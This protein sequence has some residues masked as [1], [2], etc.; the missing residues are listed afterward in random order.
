VLR[1]KLVD[2]ALELG[3]GRRAES[4]LCSWSHRT[5]ANS[6]NNCFASAMD[7]TGT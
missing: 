2:E 3:L 1:L 5:G 7:A 6:A 4:S